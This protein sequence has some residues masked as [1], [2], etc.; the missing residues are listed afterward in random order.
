MVDEVKKNINTLLKEAHEKKVITDDEKD[1]M[2][3]GEEQN[4]TLYIKCISL[5]KHQA[6]L[7]KGQSSV[8]VVA[9]L[10]ILEDLWIIIS[11]THSSYL[12]DTPHY[13]REMEDLNNA[14]VLK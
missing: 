9:L 14:G 10:K 3:C 2:E 13:L 5:T 11:N 7:Q 1:A 8:A 12:Q 4:F 6:L